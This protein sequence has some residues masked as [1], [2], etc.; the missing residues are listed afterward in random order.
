ME[1]VAYESKWGDFVH[2]KKKLNPETFLLTCVIHK[3]TKTK[4]KFEFF[5]RLPGNI[6]K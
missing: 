5:E 3:T 6:D 2:F 4:E 1:V